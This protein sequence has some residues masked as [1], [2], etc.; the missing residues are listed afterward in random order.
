MTFPAYPKYKESGIEWLGK[1]PEHWE[2]IPFKWNIKLNDGGVWGQDPTG[3]N[4]TIVLR[5]TEQTIDGKWLIEE[6]ALRQLSEQD[7]K[8]ALLST[9]DL[10]IT[11]SSG[12][13]LHIGKTTL[14]SEEVEQLNCCYSNF[15][16]RV[17]TTEN[18][19]PKLAWY[20]LNNRL[21]REQFDFLSNSTTGLANINS[22]MI[23]QI[24]A[25]NIPKDEQTTITNFLDHETAKIDALIAEQE[26]LIELLIEK[27]QSVISN[28]V[29]RGLDPKVPMKDSGVEWLGMVPQHWEVITGR[30]L[31]EIKKRIAGEL[32]YIVLSITQKGIK[33][34]D[35]ESNDGQLS[36][37][38]SKYQL[39]EVG[40]FAM[41]H[42]DL[43]TGYVDISKVKG[44]TS[45]D[46][47]VFS[48]R[49]SSYIPEYF[50]LLLQNCY[51]SKI[52]YPFGQG[53]SQLGRWRMPTTQFNEFC[54]PVPPEMEQ[55]EIVEEV[56]KSLRSFDKLQLES[57]LLTQS[58]NERRSAL[59]SAA[60]TGQIDV[61]NFQ[62]KAP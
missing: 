47:R 15:T 49:S 31:F 55:K 54:Y 59:I 26:K 35:I 12:S 60:V 2:F 27:R 18:F 39:V 57:N 29:S 32:G 4:D 10:L 30:R 9:G 21:A 3:L 13:S 28:A 25:P 19:H 52:F 45:P 62:P 7:K 17:R 11:K 58:L 40:D 6:P 24:L 51:H 16:Q 20:F 23:G 44:V 43:L 56:N 34:K 38:Y 46:Y 33:Q 5:S 1:V 48:L 14:V 53:S 41:N 8:S 37:D 42:M 50:L 36:M 61:R 22:T